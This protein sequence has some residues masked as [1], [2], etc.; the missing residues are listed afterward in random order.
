MHRKIG[1]ASLALAWYTDLKLPYGKFGRKH[2]VEIRGQST[3]LHT[4][5]K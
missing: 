3:A 4:I 1:L 5:I 2:N